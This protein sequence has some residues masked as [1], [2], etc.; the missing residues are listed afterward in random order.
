MRR[1]ILATAALLGLAATAA[2]A[3]PAKS[4]ADYGRNLI[5]VA[6]PG[7]TS[8]YAPTGDC[9]VWA[10]AEGLGVEPAQLGGMHGLTLHLNVKPLPG[11]TAT[12]FATAFAS[13]KAANPTAPAW[14]LAT[15]EKNAAAV[16]AA[17]AQDHPEP[18]KVHAFGS[19]DRAAT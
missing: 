5:S 18:F 9:I 11:E 1:P 2:T 10:N 8:T 14:F 13:A 16:E 12:S 17:C 3:A 7:R 19:G 4:E 15:L 6:T